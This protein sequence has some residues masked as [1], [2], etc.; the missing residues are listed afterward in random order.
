ME[1]ARRRE[2]KRAGIS[3]YGTGDDSFNRYPIGVLCQVNLHSADRVTV[4]AELHG[5][6][7]TYF[8]E[9]AYSLRRWQAEGIFGFSL[10]SFPTNQNTPDEAANFSIGN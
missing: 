9:K 5:E 10:A 2:K 4:A 8:R 6:Y 1:L 3:F 7:R